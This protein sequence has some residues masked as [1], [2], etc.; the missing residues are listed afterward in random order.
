M[1]LI[2]FKLTCGDKF[3]FINEILLYIYHILKY[4]LDLLNFKIK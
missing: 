1:I 4:M 2:V 3:Y